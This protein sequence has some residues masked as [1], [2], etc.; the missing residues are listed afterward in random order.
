MA[1]E[2]QL[3][4]CEA[5]DEAALALIGQ[6]TFLETFAGVLGGKDILV[7]CENAHSPELYRTWLAN[8]S[9]ALWLAEITPGGAPIG[10][11]VVAPTQLPLA[12]TSKD[13]VELKRVYVLGKFH[14]GGIGKKL[15]SEAVNHSL[16]I[17]AERLLLGVY[18]HNASA[19]GFYE[20]SG[21]IKLGVRKFNVGGQD[22]DDDIMGMPLNT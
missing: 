3:R 17:G 7:H 11:M 14:G 15:V 21:F 16:S 8:P 20:R 22:Y 10:Y 4:R 2:I 6:S 5:G 19:I 18:A 9:I 12:D 13:D 1:T